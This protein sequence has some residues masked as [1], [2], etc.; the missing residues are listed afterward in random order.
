MENLLRVS[1]DAWGQEALSGVSWDL[2]PW[3]VG[4]AGAFIVIHAA[5]KLVTSRRTRSR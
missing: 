1:R 3:F 2:L 5:V 4:A